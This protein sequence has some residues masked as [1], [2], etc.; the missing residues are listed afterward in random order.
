MIIY[1]MDNAIYFGRVGIYLIRDGDW[2]LFI[3]ILEITHN[4]RNL[5]VFIWLYRT[6]WEKWDKWDAAGN[7]GVR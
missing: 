4:V 6:A 5:R 7:L 1:L 2:E 3:I